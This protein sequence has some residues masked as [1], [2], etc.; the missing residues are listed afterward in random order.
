MPA[1]RNPKKP[2]PSDRPLS[3]PR[4]LRA[5]RAVVSHIAHAEDAAERME[6]AERMGAAWWDALDP[7]FY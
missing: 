1:D 6:R 7:S 3:G 2:D 4:T 5:P